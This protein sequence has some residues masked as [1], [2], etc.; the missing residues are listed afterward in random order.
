[1]SHLTIAGTSFA[2]DR[3]ELVAYHCAS[4]TADWNLE[5]VRDG[6]SGWLFGENDTGPEDI[7]DSN[8]EP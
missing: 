2:L 8:G 7:A 6:S 4:K 5:M 1:M 3:A